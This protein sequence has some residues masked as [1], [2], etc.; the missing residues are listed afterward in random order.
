M[1]NN[2]Q[3]PTWIVELN[4]TKQ[5]WFSFLEK[6]ETRMEELCTAAIPEL[7]EAFAADEDIH[8]RNFHKLLAGI[9]GQIENMRKKAYD[10]FE[11]KIQQTYYRLNNE[12][13]FMNP[14]HRLLYEFREQC[15]DRYFQVFEKYFHDRKTQLETIAIKDYETDYREIVEEFENIKNKFACKQCGSPIPLDRIY[16]IT[17]YLKCP[18]CQSQN[19]FQPSTKAAQLEHIGR[20]LAEQ[21]TAHLLQSYNDAQIKERELYQQAH[22]LSL[23][24]ES[25]K[26]QQIQQIETERRELIKNTPELYRKYLRAMFDEWNKINPDLADE[27][28][29]FHQRMLDEFNKFL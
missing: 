11:E 9:N 25:K 26:V 3:S 24:N 27:H 12:V 19:T 2:N 6:L 21:R 4:E 17:T 10:T 28:E 20:S 15:S 5:R 16:F 8:K 13:D 18:A 22:E 1:P 14:Q 7:K 29:K 23:G